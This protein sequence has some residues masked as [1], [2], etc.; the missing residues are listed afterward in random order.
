[1]HHRGTL[2]T[3]RMMLYFKETPLLKLC[4]MARISRR[5]IACVG[6]RLG[7]RS[8]CSRE[9][10][11]G[12]AVAYAGRYRRVE[13]QLIGFNR[14]LRGYR[15]RRSH[16]AGASVARQA[17]APPHAGTATHVPWNNDGTPESEFLWIYLHKSEVRFLANE[18]TCA[19]GAH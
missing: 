12:A 13:R 17:G 16:C 11:T 6:P 3:R 9:R 18:G 15:T 19:G 14:L 7:L 5:Y 2:C 4:G 8:Y 10:S 1:M